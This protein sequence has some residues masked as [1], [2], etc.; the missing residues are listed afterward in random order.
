MNMLAGNIYA[1]LLTGVMSVCLGKQLIAQPNLAQLEKQMWA[2]TDSEDTYEI[3]EKKA[4]E[5]GSTLLVAEYYFECNGD[6][7]ARTTYGMATASGDT[8]PPVYEDIDF[9]KAGEYVV[10]GIDF[11]VV[12]NDKLKV[13]R[14]MGKYKRLAY[15]FVVT[16]ENGKV[17]VKDE[18]GNIT[19]PFKYE[20]ID[21]HWSVEN[22]DEESWE[23]AYFDQFS[24][25][26]EGKWGVIE[27]GKEKPIIPFEYD[28]IYSV[29][30]TRAVV[31]KGQKI[32]FVDAE[33]VL[34]P[35]EYDEIDLG[36]GNHAVRKG[37]KWGF[38]GA[39]S[40]KVI[41]ECKYDEYTKQALYGARWV[42]EGSKWSA[43]NG[44]GT[45]ITKTTYDAIQSYGMDMTPV[46]KGGKWG[47]FDTR[48]EKEAA[49]CKYD[50]VVRFFG[51]EAE[52]MLNGDKVTIDLEVY[53]EDY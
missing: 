50:K 18:A 48:T 40:Y 51:H 27:A 36:M 23:E 10:K 19:I 20:D 11:A 43:I 37:E 38:I 53:D 39:T 22:F 32:G 14:S 7:C 35:F 45:V 28:W 21:Q 2:V 13:I 46:K 52:V 1:Y 41:A 30:N 3:F 49:P 33:Q 29:K 24:C 26:L 44:R 12:I 6:I 47:F 4:M 8:L 15:G 17:G 5:D 9:V 25:K 34:V 31:K 16:E 42:R